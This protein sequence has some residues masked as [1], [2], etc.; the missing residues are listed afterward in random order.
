MWKWFNCYLSGRHNFAV[1]CEPGAIFLLCSHCGRRSPGWKVT[2]K[3]N[4]PATRPVE[5]IAS[6][7]RPVAGSAPAATPNRRVLPLS[8]VAA[9]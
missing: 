6:I 9:S 1:S 2:N 4:A 3:T 8:G 5:K 7:S